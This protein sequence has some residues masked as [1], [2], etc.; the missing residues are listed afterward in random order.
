MNLGTRM[1]VHFLLFILYSNF[2]FPMPQSA[3][4]DWRMALIWRNDVA[5]LEKK[6]TLLFCTS[7][8]V[9]SCRSREDTQISHVWTKRSHCLISDVTALP[10]WNYSVCTNE[11]S[12]RVCFFISPL[13]L[14]EIEIR[15]LWMTG[16]CLFLKFYM[17]LISV[18]FFPCHFC[19]EKKNTTLFIFCLKFCGCFM[20]FIF[21]QL[22][23]LFLNV[24]KREPFTCFCF[25]L[26]GHSWQMNNLY[27]LFQNRT[28]ERS[29]CD[30]T[31]LSTKELILFN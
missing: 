20:H 6:K 15:G 22:P 11:A 18:V 2:F 7:D 27:L 21:V 30:V 10:L 17:S 3:H 26:M 23:A 31:V 28:A 24:N 12:N 25:H 4:F 13:V 1:H 8:C 16:T 19:K 5:V 29:V 9:F 14:S